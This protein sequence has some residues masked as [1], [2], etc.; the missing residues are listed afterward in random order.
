MT[1]AISSLPLYLIPQKLGAF[2]RSSM[3]IFRD[4]FEFV[5]LYLVKLAWFLSFMLSQLGDP[6]CESLQVPGVLSLWG[7]AIGT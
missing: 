1:S 3:W 5:A 6:L 2:R 4:D 7:T